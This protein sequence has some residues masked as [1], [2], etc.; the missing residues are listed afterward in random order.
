MRGVNGFF[1]E[2]TSNVRGGSASTSSTSSAPA[3]PGSPG[4][5]P[6]GNASNSS[7]ASSPP[8]KSSFGRTRAITAIAAATPSM[9]N[10]RLLLAA[11]GAPPTITGSVMTLPPGRSWSW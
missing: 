6:A 5:P 7:T 10:A 8:A 9:M 2:N 3:T 11:T 4:A 1:V